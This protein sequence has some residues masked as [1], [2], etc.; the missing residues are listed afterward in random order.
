M[1]KKAWIDARTEVIKQCGG[2]SEMQKGREN[3]NFDWEKLD[4]WDS[5]NSKKVL[6]M[7]SDNTKPLLFEDID[8]EMPELPVYEAV[9]GRDEHGRA[10][11]DGGK[12][13][14]DNKKIIN[15]L[16]AP[17]RNQY[18]GEVDPKML[19][20]GAKAKIKLLES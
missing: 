4:N 5:R 8:N 9:I 13:Y 15:Q 2:M 1:N 11:T 18:T 6:R 14:D 10:I 20:K 16:L 19:T 3:S 7:N 17:C 12:T